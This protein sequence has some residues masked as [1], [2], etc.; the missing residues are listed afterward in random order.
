MAVV[1]DRRSSGTVIDDEGIEL[2]ALAQLLQDEN[3]RQNTHI[4]VT[5]YN[6]LTLVTG[7]ATNDALKQ[8]AEN[9]VRRIPNVREVYNEVRIAQPSTFLSRSSDALITS[10]IKAG[11]FK[12]MDMPDFDPTRVK[13]VTENGVV[14]L[15]GLLTERE[16]DQV[17]NY[18]RTVNGVQKV[19][20]I[21]EYLTPRP[22]AL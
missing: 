4:N 1:H 3:I 9:I 18:A 13:V 22:P 7:E 19:V 15:M 10:T 20:K 16:A 12:F 17:A 2:K 8:R 6:Y 11:L 14:F 5:S 21:V